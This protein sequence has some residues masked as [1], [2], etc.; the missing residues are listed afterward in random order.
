MARMA[1]MG[2][3]VM[4]AT[5][6]HDPLAV[7]SEFIALS[8]AEAVPVSPMKVIKLV[9]LAHG[10]CL[11]LAKRPLINERVKAW[12]FGPVVPSVERL[13]QDLSGSMIE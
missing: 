6:Q 4:M 5:R 11:A 13:S 8:K 9:C 1:R 7:A 10:W 3:T 2:D 12:R